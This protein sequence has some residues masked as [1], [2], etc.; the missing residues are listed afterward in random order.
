MLSTVDFSKIHVADF[1][2]GK[3]CQT[4]TV[5]L[6]GK[7]LQFRLSQ[8]K[9]YKMPFGASSFE[10]DKETTRLNLDLDISGMSEECEKLDAW[11]LEYAC[12]EKDRLFPE[13]S[14]EDIIRNYYRCVQHSEKYGTTRL[15]TK[16]NTAGL[17]KC[18]C[19]LHP[20]KNSVDVNDYDLRSASARPL[21]TFR[22]FWKQGRGFGL[23]LVT[24]ALLLSPTE[25]ECPF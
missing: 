12:K 7:D 3:G 11:A 10:K 24:T 9:F 5:S 20:E 25:E 15:R 21:I 4:A 22:G 1:A 13:M 6:D 2:R 23:S 18:K 17:N 19:F 8:D 14:E 16:I